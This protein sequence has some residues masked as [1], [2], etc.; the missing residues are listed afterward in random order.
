M[1]K[2][3]FIVFIIIISVMAYSGTTDITYNRIIQEKQIWFEEGEWHRKISAKPD[4]SVDIEALYAH[5][6]RH[7]NLWEQVF[8]CLA[9]IDLEG[10]E[11]GRYPIAGDS[12]F[13]IVDEYLTQDVNERKYEAHNKYIDLQ[14]VISGQELIGISKLDKQEVLE[15]YEEDRDIAF[16]KIHDGEF[17]LAD[18]SV[19]FIFFPD[20][21]HQPCVKVNQSAPVRKI[22]FKIISDQ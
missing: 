5:Y 20:D 21:A 10:I 9:E 18:N 16:F 22:V 13:M 11:T 3:I 19:F 8:N 7:S 17:R 2:T 12:L 1:K 14:Y 4:A 6:T 15:P